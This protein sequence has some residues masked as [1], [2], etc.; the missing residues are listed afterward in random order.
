MNHLNTFDL[1]QHIRSP[2]HCSGHTL[3]LL[4]TRH[5]NSD[6]IISTNV[7]SDAPS[8]HAYIIFDL[9]FPGPKRSKVLVNA[10]KIK[11]IN[12]ELFVEDLNQ[13]DFG[14]ENLPV[15]ELRSL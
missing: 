9:H 2:I 4:I 14:T 6:T 10:R 15:D 7:F 1:K 8:N 13:I 5:L 3:D 12:M 11:S